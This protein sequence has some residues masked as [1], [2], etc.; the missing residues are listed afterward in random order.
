MMLHYSESID[1]EAVAISLRDSMETWTS[2]E[3][4]D[5]IFIELLSDCNDMQLLE[6]YNKFN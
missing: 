4:I 1:F 6:Y 5:F 2:K 3:L